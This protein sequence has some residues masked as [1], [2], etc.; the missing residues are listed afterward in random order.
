M[1]DTTFSEAEAIGRIAGA[2]TA[3]RTEL[4]RGAKRSASSR[5][6]LW[7]AIAN[8]AGKCASGIPAGVRPRAPKASKIVAAQQEIKEA[9]L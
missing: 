3:I 9:Q 4:T 5:R 8:E 1:S 6:A 7:D 2:L